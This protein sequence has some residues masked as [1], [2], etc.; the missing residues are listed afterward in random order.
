MQ[1]GTHQLVAI[2]EI[3]LDKSNPRIAL[4]LSMYEEDPTPEQIY[5]ALGAGVDDKEGQSGTKFVTLKNS[6][7]THGGVI[8]PVILNQLADGKKICIEGNTRVCLY[9]LFRSQ[10]AKGSWD[11]IPAIVYKDLSDEEID[12]IRLQAHL[13]GP[14]QWDPYAKAKYLTYL[15]NGEKFSFAKLV[16]YC[17]GS[18]KSVSESIE[19]YADM[20]EYY[21]PLCE[22]EGD[23]DPRRFSGFVE[24][25]KNNVKTA[26]LRAGYSVGDFAKWIYD[27]AIDPLNTVRWLPKILADKKATQVFLKKGARE[28]IKTLDRPD[29]SSALREAT[30][31][32]LAQALSEAINRIPYSEVRE[33]EE[34]PASDANQT[35]LDTQDAVNTFISSLKKDE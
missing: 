10:K 32:Q 7:Q 29:L 1:Q 30:V 33:L 21:R 23:F 6:I 9:K 12:A 34:D 25:E 28:A 14:R 35:L 17:G 15:R 16:D 3:I 4:W 11:T 18:R 31:I 24:L 27:R 26:I 8:Q 13:V 2:D 22:S 19:A 20:E 5:Q